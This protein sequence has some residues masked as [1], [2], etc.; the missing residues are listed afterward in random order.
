MCTAGKFRVIRDRTAMP[1]RITRSAKLVL[2]RKSAKRLI[3]N[4]DS[5]RLEKA[6]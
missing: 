3:L 6:T 2:L 5:L 4:R 1:G